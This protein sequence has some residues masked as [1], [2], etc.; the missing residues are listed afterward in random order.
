LKSI[1]ILTKTKMPISKPN[2]L[3]QVRKHLG[4]EQKQIINLLGHSVI[5]QISR[6]ETGQRLPSLRT[7]LKF[8]ILYKLPVR[9]LFQSSYEQAGEELTRRHHQ[10]GGQS[11]LKIDL[12]E[13][14]DYCSYI[15][16][17]NSPF[18]TEIDKEKVRRHIRQMMYERKDRILGH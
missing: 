13:P 11:I 18:V 16:L 6:W 15:E 10:L 5:S 1:S 14:V 3:W 8:E 17:M 7:A 9:V 4:Y 12:T 2:R